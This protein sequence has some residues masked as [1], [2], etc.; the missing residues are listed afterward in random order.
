MKLRT[1]II[2]F[3]LWLLAC[4]GA[5]IVT[6]FYGAVGTIFL[7]GCALIIVFIKREAPELVMREGKWYDEEKEKE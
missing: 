4:I 6:T 3:I 5:A 7:I 1:A 2:V